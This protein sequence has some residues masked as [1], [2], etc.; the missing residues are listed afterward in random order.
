MDGLPETSSSSAAPIADD[1][2]RLNWT[3]N[4]V[5]NTIISSEDNEIMYEVTTANLYSITKRLTTVTRL[6]KASGKKVFAG[7]IAWKALQIRTE[8]RVGWQNCE[9][10]LAQEWLKNSKGISTAKTFTAA[11]GTQYRWKFRDL[12]Y[13]V[14]KT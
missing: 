10:I 9:W 13:H 7:E 6:D 14:R 3:R 11:Q 1:M 4:S 12:K 5:Y 8:V 2:I